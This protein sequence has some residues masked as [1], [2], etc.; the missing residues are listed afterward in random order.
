[1]NI[2]AKTLTSAIPTLFLILCG[3]ASSG[4]EGE[5]YTDSDTPGKQAR[6]GEFPGCK[7][8]TETAA[9][10]LEGRL[11]KYPRRALR[12]GESGFADIRFSISETGDVENTEILRA[13]SEEF[14]SNVKEAVGSWKFQPAT[15]EDRPVTVVCAKRNSFSADD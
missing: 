14:A 11:P 12:H 3:C 2:L 7:P 9:F 13:T 10:L 4:G 8:S 15:N 5:S 6:R 1:M